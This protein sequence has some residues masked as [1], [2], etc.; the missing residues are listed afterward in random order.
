MTQNR[1]YMK[2]ITV[3]TAGIIT[4]ISA[5]IQERDAGDHLGDLAAALF[6]DNAG[7]PDLL[8]AGSNVQL[9]TVG[10]IKA[11][12]VQGSARWF[13]RAMGVYVTATDYW[14][15]VTEPSG[16]SGHR[17]YKDGSGSDRY[18]TSAGTWIIDSGFYTVTTST[19][20]YS[21]RASI[22]S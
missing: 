6:T 11:A 9:V 19:D 4:S 13:H 20:K 15:A 10:L 16:A 5:Y 18:Y 12:G 7:S 17:I 3:A 1:V 14:I 2:K 8:I 22:I 21:I